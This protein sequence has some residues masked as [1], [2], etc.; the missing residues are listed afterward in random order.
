MS[1]RTYVKPQIKRV[2][3]TIE[4]AVLTNCKTSTGGAPK[5]N[6]CKTAGT[7]A[8]CKTAVGS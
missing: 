4:D 6:T 8:C 2:K 5:N 3:L 7:G 1:K